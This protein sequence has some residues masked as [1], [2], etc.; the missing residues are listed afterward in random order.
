MA[1]LLHTINDDRE[2]R[3]RAYTIL[4]TL[5]NFI[6]K[7]LGFLR[8]WDSLVNKQQNDWADVAT[9]VHEPMESEY[10]WWARDQVVPHGPP[11]YLINPIPWTHTQ[12]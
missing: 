6:V 2:G 1:M 7:P 10:E 8:V 12:R 5:L 11:P 9:H 3:G 4:K